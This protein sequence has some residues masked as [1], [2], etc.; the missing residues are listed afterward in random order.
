MR[1]K[2][3]RGF[4]KEHVCVECGEQAQEW[5]LISKTLSEASEVGRPT[6]HSHSVENY[7]PMCIKCHRK[8]DVLERVS[9][10]PKG[11]PYDEANTYI[12]KNRH[13]SRACRACA[14]ERAAHKRALSK[15]NHSQKE[16]N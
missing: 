8:Q 3:E 15:C 6:G 7:Q 9:H 14:R 13:F 2:A 16:S 12:R 4:A 1:L 11:H 5:A 10:C